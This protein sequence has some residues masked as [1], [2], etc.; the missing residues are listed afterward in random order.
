MQLGALSDPDGSDVLELVR[1]VARAGG[2]APHVFYAPIVVDNPAMARS[3]RR[4]PEVARALKL[5]DSGL[6][7]VGGYRIMGGRA[8]PPGSS[9]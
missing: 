2:G 8:S 1:Q 9:C 6:N 5:I 3:L 4:Q 7:C